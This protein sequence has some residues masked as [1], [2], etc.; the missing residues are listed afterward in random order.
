[1]KS[2]MQWKWKL[3]ETVSLQISKRML[4][5]KHTLLFYF[6]FE[7]QCILGSGLVLFL[8][9]VS[10][11]DV[12]EVNLLVSPQNIG[13]RSLVLRLFHNERLWDVNETVCKTHPNTGWGKSIHFHTH[14]HVGKLRIYWWFC[15][16]IPVS[17]P[18]YIYFYKIFCANSQILLKKYNYA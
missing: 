1:M 16:C 12:F 13:F 8:L 11:I 7:D 3:H 6:K 10:V 9:F 14:L 15:T 18:I 2:Q 17:G 4:L 5:S